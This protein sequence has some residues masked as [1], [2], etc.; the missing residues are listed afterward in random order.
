MMIDRERRV[1]GDFALEIEPT[2]LATGEMEFGFCTKCA[3][4]TDAIAVADN[5][6]PQQSGLRSD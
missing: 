3:L 2:K 1:I 4:A 6:H 5:Q